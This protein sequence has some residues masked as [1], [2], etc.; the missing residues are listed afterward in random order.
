MKRRLEERIRLGIEGGDIDNPGIKITKNLSLL[1]L[2]AL[3]LLQRPWKRLPFLDLS[4]L[5]SFIQ[6]S[7]RTT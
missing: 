1:K 2:R 6:I 5:F 7:T 3:A 4:F